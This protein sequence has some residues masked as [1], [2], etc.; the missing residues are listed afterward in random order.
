ME[1]G[2]RLGEEGGG[3][4]LETGPRPLLHF[5]LALFIFIVLSFFSLHVRATGRTH[6]PSNTHVLCS[7]PALGGRRRRVGRPGLAERRPEK[8]QKKERERGSRPT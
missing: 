6:V 4:M 3:T 7:R 2:K 1:Q 8:R 5:S